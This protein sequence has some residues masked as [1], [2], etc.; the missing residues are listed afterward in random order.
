VKRARRTDSGNGAVVLGRKRHGEAKNCIEDDA[1]GFAAA[2][3]LALQ[4]PA[5]HAGVVASVVPARYFTKCHHR[6]LSAVQ[7][8][9]I[10][11]F[12]TTSHS[13]SHLLRFVGGKLNEYVML[14]CTN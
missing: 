7:K 11:G 10:S 13:E 5:T 12:F 1:D 2:E 6:G 4:Q 3:V 9:T 14:C 8:T